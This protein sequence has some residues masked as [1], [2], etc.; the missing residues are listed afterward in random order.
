MEI[1][2]AAGIGILFGVSLWFPYKHILNKL[3]QKKR[4]TSAILNELSQ[5]ER[6]HADAMQYADVKQ[7][8]RYAT[9]GNTTT[10]TNVGSWQPSKHWSSTA[11]GVNMIDQYYNN[12]I[13]SGQ[14]GNA[15]AVT[16]TTSPASVSSTNLDARYCTQCKLMVESESHSCQHGTSAP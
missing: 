12:L 2:I 1:G 16:G 7:A 13:A 14:F 15:Q 8:M 6:E 4:E 9:M 11:S 10:T 5:S 3:V